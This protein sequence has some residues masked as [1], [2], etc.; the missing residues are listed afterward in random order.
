LDLLSQAPAPNNDMRATKDD[1]LYLEPAAFPGDF[2]ADVPP[3][4]AHTMA[5]RSVVWQKIY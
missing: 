1:F 3:A 5:R 4:Q 2:A